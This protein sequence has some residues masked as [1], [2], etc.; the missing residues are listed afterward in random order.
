MKIA[1][2]VV[3]RVLGHRRLFLNVFFSY[4]TNA[5]AHDDRRAMLFKPAPAPVARLHF[6]KNLWLTVQSALPSSLATPGD[7]ARIR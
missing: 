3:E 7:P 1:V 2:G 5:F 6:P 4:D